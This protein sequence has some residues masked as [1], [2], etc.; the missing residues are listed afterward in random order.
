MAVA[1][2]HV[3]A[4]APDVGD[5]HHTGALQGDATEIGVEVHLQPD[6]HRPSLEYEF[7][8]IE[9]IIPTHSTITVIWRYISSL[10]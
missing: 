5:V 6:G 7:H 2:K 3:L 8:C 1:E 9:E 4:G 10:L